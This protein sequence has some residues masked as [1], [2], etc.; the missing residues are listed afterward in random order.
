MNRSI[1][2][3]LFC[4][5][6]PSLSIRI[7]RFICIFE[8]TSNL[9]YYYQV[10]VYYIDISHFVFS[11]ACRLAFGW[12]LVVR[13][14]MKICMITFF[15]FSWLNTQARNDW[16]M[17]VCVFN[18]LRNWQMAFILINRDTVLESL[19]II[20]KIKWNLRMG[21]THKGRQGTLLRSYQLSSTW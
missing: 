10:V 21:A 9:F 19:S 12:F 14:N 5:Q 4:V 8:C 16:I 6:F 13:N 15:F 17:W 11:F 3:I 7:L 2:D 18:F 1:Q 20:R